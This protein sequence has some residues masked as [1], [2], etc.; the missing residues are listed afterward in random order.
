MYFMLYLFIYI[1]VN[2]L[3]DNYLFIK[4]DILTFLFICG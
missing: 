4:L 1:P 3:I 2:N